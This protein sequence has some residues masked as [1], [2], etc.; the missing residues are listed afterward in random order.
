MLLQYSAERASPKKIY[1]GGLQ[2]KIFEKRNCSKIKKVY[3]LACIWLNECVYRIKKKMLV[4]CGYYDGVCVCIKRIKSLQF[5]LSNIHIFFYN[6]TKLLQ[7]FFYIFSL[8]LSVNSSKKTNIIDKY[9]LLTF[10]CYLYY[11]CFYCY[12]AAGDLIFF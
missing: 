11:C 7:A 3:L 9:E 8:S 2:P 4:L 6:I 12:D 10:V 5:F 1:R